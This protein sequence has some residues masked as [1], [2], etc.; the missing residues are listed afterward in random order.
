MPDVQDLSTMTLAMKF[1]D[2]L[3]IPASGAGAIGLEVLPSTGLAVAIA[4]IESGMIKRNRMKR[5]PRQGPQSVT[6]SYE[7]EV[8][9][10]AEDM[11]YEA[12][13]GGPK[14]IPAVKTQ[15][16][17]GTLTITGTGTIATFST[18][19]A[20]VQ[21]ALFPGLFVRFGGAGNKWVPVVSVASGVVHLA[22]GYLVDAGVAAAWTMDTAPYFATPV[23]YIDKYASIEEAMTEPGIATSKY[24][25][26]VR[27]NSLNFSVEPKTYVKVAFGAEG[28]DFKQLK[29]PGVY[30]AFADPVYVDRD[31][32]ILNDGGVFVNGVKRL[33]MTSLKMGISAPISKVDV[34]GTNIPPDISV[35]QY[36]FAGDFTGVV[37]DS[38]DFDTFSAEDDI[39]ICLHCKEK[40]S[41]AF[42]GIYAGY[43]LFGGYATPMGGE[44]LVIQSL[45]LF[46][47]ED[48]R[49]GALKS[50]FVISTAPA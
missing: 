22:P 13:L 39:S 44:G 17:W 49:P 7:T 20:A 28:R 18:G 15:A 1:Q 46:G 6:T 8:T 38:V 41:N 10:S 33:D 25:T 16:D 14:I 37:A 35:G 5:R 32:L 48:E 30:P 26:D 9:V 42:V 36:A 40:N 45:P 3:G 27:F 47:G 34:I 23:I 19:A 24:G 11:I 50:I 29:G 21:A 12:V 43:L 31:S 4:A 2:G